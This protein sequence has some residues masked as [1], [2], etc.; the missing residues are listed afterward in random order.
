MMADLAAFQAALKDAGC[1]SG[2]VDSANVPA[3]GAVNRGAQAQEAFDRAMASASGAPGVTK[4][5][6]VTATKL[7]ELDS[8]QR[9]TNIN[10]RLNAI[11]AMRK[12]S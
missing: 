1:A 2:D 12:A 11:K 6:R 3:S 4:A 8:V 7:R 10:E 9:Q 5:D